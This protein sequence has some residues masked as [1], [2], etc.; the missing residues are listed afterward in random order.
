MDG[1]AS[2]LDSSRLGNTG[3]LSLLLMHVAPCALADS[4]NNKRSMSN[5]AGSWRDEHHFW[6][7][8]DVAS[9]NSRV[10]M[11]DVDRTHDIFSAKRQDAS[12][13]AARLK[14]SLGAQESHW[15]EVAEPAASCAKSF[16]QQE[17]QE[18][19]ANA[20]GRSVDQN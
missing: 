13:S 10:V 8:K 5:M 16:K 18:C 15:R 17:W 11:I 1:E 12:P 9:I 14:N 6:H 7:S 3:A 4:A 19:K 2:L 20:H